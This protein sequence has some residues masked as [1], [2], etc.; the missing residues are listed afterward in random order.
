[1]IHLLLLLSGIGGAIALRSHT[2]WQ[3]PCQDCRWQ[4][5][6]RAFVVPPLLLLSTATALVLMGTHGQM[7]QGWFGTAPY[8]IAVTFLLAALMIGLCQGVRSF[9]TLRRVVGRPMIDLLEQPAYLVEGDRPFIAQ[10]G[11]WHPKLV[12]TQCLLETLDAEHLNAVLRHEAAHQHFHDTFWFFLLGCLRRLTF[13]LPQNQALWQELL[14]LRELRADRWAAQQVDPLLLAEALY[15][16]VSPPIEPELA[17]GFNHSETN[18]EDRLE[19][20]IQALLSPNPPMRANPWDWRYV[21]L[22]LLPLL[23]I[24]LH[25]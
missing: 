7:A 22:V 21:V 24:P 16:V 20:R 23:V 3:T 18:P 10:I 12:L 17:A 4:K 13:W 8:G 19:T 25:R 5:S 15:Q 9:V 14:S 11:L 6:M 1:M 2:P